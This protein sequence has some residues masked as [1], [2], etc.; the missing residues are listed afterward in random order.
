MM[1]KFSS[2]QLALVMCALTATVHGAAGQNHNGMWWGPLIHR[3]GGILVTGAPSDLCGENLNG[4]YKPDASRS[5]S[6][7]KDGESISRNWYV[8]QNY[9]TLQLSLVL[10]HTTQKCNFTSVGNN[11]DRFFG[12]V[13]VDMRKPKNGGHRGAVA[14]RFGTRD[15]ITFKPMSIA[16]VREYEV[17]QQ[18][19]HDKICKE[20]LHGVPINLL[21]GWL[22]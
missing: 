2:Y 21:K 20:N 9:K 1:M 11:T 8:I 6:Y 3:N 22:N 19:V 14:Y 13:R 5:H 7:V 4:V 18:T 17:N 15:G 12:N 10:V 16:D